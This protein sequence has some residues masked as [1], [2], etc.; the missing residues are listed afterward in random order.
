MT[1]VVNRLF[2]PTRSEQTEP[3]ASASGSADAADLDVDEQR[4]LLAAIRLGDAA[5]AT[6]VGLERGDQ[7]GKVERRAGRL[8]GR[9]LAPRTIHGTVGDEVTDVELAGATRGIDRDRCDRVEPEQREI[10]EIVAR[11]RLVAQ[12]GVDEPE[13][14]E[15]ALAAAQTTDICAQAQAQDRRSRCTPC[16][17]PRSGDRMTRLGRA[18]SPPASST[19]A[20]RPR[21]ASREARSESQVARHSSSHERSRVTTRAST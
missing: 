1:I 4:A 5:D 6:E 19:H 15:P 7:L 3:A 11:E 9:E 10:G 2:A 8:L 18:R 20:D 17:A 12:V 13:A 21:S 16:R 14:T